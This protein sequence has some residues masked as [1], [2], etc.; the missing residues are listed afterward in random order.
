MVHP[1]LYMYVSEKRSDGDGDIGL[2]WDINEMERRLKKLNAGH[3]GD[4]GGDDEGKS[5]SNFD[6]LE[7]R[8]RKLR[9]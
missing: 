7:A 9:K 5:G 1:R 2:S 3:R 6:D 4:E 8:Y